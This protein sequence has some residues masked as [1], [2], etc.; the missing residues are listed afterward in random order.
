MWSVIARG[1]YDQ[2]IEDQEK[3]R[4]RVLENVNLNSEEG[5][6]ELMKL[7]NEAFNLGDN[8]RWLMEREIYPL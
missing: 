7:T 8:I 6:K 2:M 1:K 4:Q 3:H 5:F